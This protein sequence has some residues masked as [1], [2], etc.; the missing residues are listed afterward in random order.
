MRA[1]SV[2]WGAPGTD[3]R[4]WR[5]AGCAS[6]R[7]VRPPFGCV[8]TAQHACMAVL[9]AF[10]FKTIMGLPRWDDTRQVRLEVVSTVLR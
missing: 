9:W 4:T 8:P 2:L 5:E 10:R 1:R 6:S 7:T 3:M